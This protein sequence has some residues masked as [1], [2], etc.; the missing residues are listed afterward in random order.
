MNKII[1]AQS[2]GYWIINLFLS[3]LIV[4]LFAVCHDHFY[5][6][7]N[8]LIFNAIFL[9][10][11]II[12]LAANAVR[13]VFSLREICAEGKGTLLITILISL[14]LSLLVILFIWNAGFWNT[15]TGGLRI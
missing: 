2:H 13:S 5:G 14:V 7:S 9:T 4:F 1:S 6:T 11:A 8:E 10:L 12:Q 3:L 15:D